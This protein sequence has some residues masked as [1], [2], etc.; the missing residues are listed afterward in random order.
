MSCKNKNNMNTKNHI[1]HVV[2]FSVICFTWLAESKLKIEIVS[3]YRSMPI[4][5]HC[6]DK[7]NKKLHAQAKLTI[8]QYLSFECKKPLWRDAECSCQVKFQTGNIKSF[9]AYKSKRDKPYCENNCR[10]YVA[11]IGL[12]LTDGSFRR[13]NPPYYLWEQK[14]GH[15]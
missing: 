4:H 5:V 1:I 12:R 10:W 6:T 7:Y 15:S 8:G 9:F 14:W 11:A 13:D 2:F 3:D